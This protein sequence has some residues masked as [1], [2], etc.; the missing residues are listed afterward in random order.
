MRE[1][2]CRCVPMRP[3]YECPV[4]Q[5]PAGSNASRRTDGSGRSLV[6]TSPRPGRSSAVC[7][8]SLRRCM[9]ADEVYERP[10]RAATRCCRSP[11]SAADDCARPCLTMRQP[12]EVSKPLQRASQACQALR[13]ARR[14]S[15]DF[16]AHLA[17]RPRF[18]SSHRSLAHGLVIRTL[19]S[20]ICTVTGTHPG[21]ATEA[22]PSVLICAC[23]QKP[24][25]RGRR[26][27]RRAM[28]L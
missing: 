24:G 18:R 10:I 9:F 3:P 14:S 21:R 19:A 8:P 26:C 11:R 16:T 23:R 22:Q 7:V 20:L 15:G 27:A 12:T 4:Q 17:T 5:A 6:H 25:G 2:G 28:S 13:A 1:D